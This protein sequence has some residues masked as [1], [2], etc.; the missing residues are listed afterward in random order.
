MP[1]RSRGPGALAVRRDAGQRVSEEGERALA[2]ICSLWPGRCLAALRALRRGRTGR[3]GHSGLL[4][5][6]HDRSNARVER[7][8]SSHRAAALGRRHADDLPGRSLSALRDAGHRG[9]REYRPHTRRSLVRPGGD[10]TPLR[11]PGRADRQS[12]DG[13]LEL[14]VCDAACAPYPAEG[15][16][17]TDA[18]VA[19]DRTIRSAPHQDF[20]RLAEPHD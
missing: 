7:A 2:G 4:A 18:R 17:M 10:G 19:R 13:A 3:R 11:G 8:H 14:R 6:P 15:S 12:V 20:A 9:S 16:W 5:Q 1:G